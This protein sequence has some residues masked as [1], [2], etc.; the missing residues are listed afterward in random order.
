MQAEFK[1]RLKGNAE[2][3]E[4]VLDALLAPERLP[5]EIARPERLMAAMQHATLAGGKRL[6]PF[7]V[8]ETARLFGTEGEGV[9]RA[10]AALECVHCYSLVHDDLPAMDDDDLRRGKPTVHKAFDEATAILVGDALLTLAFDVLGEEATAASA[11]TR[12]ALVTSLARA[13]GIGGMVG[14]QL[15]DL[16]AEGRFTAEGHP[17]AL[18]ESDILRLQ[19]MKTGALL[20]AAVEMGAILGDADGDERR[21]LAAYGRALGQAFQIADDI[22]DAEG[23]AATMGKAVGKD[24]AKGKGTLVQLWG[25][26]VARGRLG[27]LVAQAE[28]ALEM[29]GERAGILRAAA[30]FV[31]ERQ[32]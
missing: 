24:M 29:F 4:G 8:I 17:L 12:I 19:A 14:G 15:L 25:L 6:R 22:L 2:A 32:S 9:L 30:R 5:G 1:D 11:E 31:A 13:S 7:L 3:V 20:S 26:D 18:D 27:D 16:S 28:A 21:A 10:G 23:D